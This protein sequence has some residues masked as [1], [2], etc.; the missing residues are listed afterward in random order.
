[1]KTSIKENA[2]LMSGMTLIELLMVILVVFALTGV[3][4]YGTQNWK[5]GGDQANCVLR[6]EKHK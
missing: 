4:W 1:M 2:K 3:M 6:L 5:N